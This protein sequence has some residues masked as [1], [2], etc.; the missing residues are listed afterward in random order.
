MELP[1]QEKS[2]KVSTP[3]IGIV[4]ALVVACILAWLSIGEPNLVYVDDLPRS[5]EI[6]KLINKNGKQVMHV[7]M[8]L[9]FRNWG[10]K[11]GHIDKVEVVPVGLNPY[12]EHVEVL[13]VDKTDIKWLQKKDIICEFIVEFDP[14]SKHYEND[15][16]EFKVHFYGSTG[17]E[18]TWQIVRAYLTFFD[19]TGK[20][21]E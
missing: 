7:K 19:S 13:H 14:R 1:K 3:A 10:L 11:S 15:Q 5:P 6:V 12:P 8:E 9:G 4:S 21:R 2:S 18:I 16:P 17:N 20:K